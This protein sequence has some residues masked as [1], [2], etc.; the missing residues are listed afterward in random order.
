MRKKIYSSD[1]T[2]MIPFF[3]L[4]CVRQSSA[5]L[6]HHYHRHS[7]DTLCEVFIWIERQQQQ[8]KNQHTEATCHVMTLIISIISPP[9]LSFYRRVSL[10]LRL[11][12]DD[13]W[14]NERRAELWACLAT[15]IELCSVAHHHHHHSSIRIHLLLLVARNLKTLSKP[16]EMEK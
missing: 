1:M 11:F 14:C 16:E 9:M 3:S 2:L 4:S 12:D 8:L 13:V 5:P 15:F 7:S 6:G 10:A